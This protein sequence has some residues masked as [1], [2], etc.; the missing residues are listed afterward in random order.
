MK[1]PV[2]EGLSTARTSVVHLEM[3]DSYL[4]GDP[5]FVAWQRGKRLDPN[6]ERST[7]WRPFLDVVQEVTSRGV[8]MQRARI[9]SEP[10]TEYIRYEHHVS[11]PNIAAGEL[12]RWLP[13]RLAA[14][15]PLPGTDFW[16]FDEESV[17]FTYFSGTGEVVDREWCRDHDVVAMAAVAFREVWRRATPHE[18]YKLT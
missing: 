9:V 3:R 8:V 13:R 11:F 12:I 16:M 6:A 17:L 15:I 1:N 4:P 14:D 7:W 18:D 2:L 10:V 5:E